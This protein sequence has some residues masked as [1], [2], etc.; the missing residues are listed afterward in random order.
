MSWGLLPGRRGR[1]SPRPAHPAS[2]A[3]LRPP[4][5]G[6]IFVE[7]DGQHVVINAKSGKV[8]CADATLRGR[9]EKALGRMHAALSPC[10][11]SDLG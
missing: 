4:S 1:C 8:Q 5:Q 6:L 3:P 9:V 11:V 10:D 2:N 7:V